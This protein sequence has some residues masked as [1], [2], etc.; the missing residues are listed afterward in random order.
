MK[1]Y[2]VR[3]VAEKSGRKVGTYLTSPTGAGTTPSLQGAYVFNTRSSRRYT[4]RSVTPEALERH[5]LEIVW[6]EL[7]AP[8]EALHGTSWP[9]SSPPSRWRWRPA[10]VSPR[11]SR[12]RPRLPAR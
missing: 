2:V 3:V 8:P 5:G 11:W 9:A 12:S 7:A 6:V 10:P 1:N 4:Y